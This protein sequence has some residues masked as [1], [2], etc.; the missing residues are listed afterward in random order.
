MLRHE[1][2]LK[3]LLASA[4]ALIAVVLSIGETSAQGVPP[5]PAVYSGIATAAGVP[6]PDGYLIYARI[7]SV[8][9][10]EPVAVS[11]GQYKFLTVAPP[12]TNFTGKLI[13][14]IIE[15][16]TA[17]ETD[18]WSS[19]K[20]DSNFD[21]SFPKLPEP[22]PTPSPIPTDTPTPSPIP[23]TP[24]STPTPTVAEPMTFA[25][26]LVIVTGGVLTP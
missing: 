26:G 15:D 8:Y 9:Q 17:T 5:I 7:G 21:L 19:G 12:D 18:T 13:T 16:I 25:A 1:L 14:F 11:D 23:P 24:I 20:F 3:Y 22:T 10:S 2:R 4:V 6:V